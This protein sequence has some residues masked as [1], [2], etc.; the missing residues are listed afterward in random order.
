M[1]PQ[2]QELEEGLTVSFF[3]IKVSFR[4]IKQAILPCK[5]SS[6]QDL[7]YFS[8]KLRLS[9]LENQYHTYVGHACNIWVTGTTV[10]TDSVSVIEKNLVS[11]GEIEW[12]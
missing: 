12:L 4:V 11:A 7:P 8:R 3:M 9:C 5:H 1:H 10:Y 6:N 2:A